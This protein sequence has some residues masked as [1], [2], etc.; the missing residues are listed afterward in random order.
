MLT[1]KINILWAIDPKKLIRN[2][3]ANELWDYTYKYFFL[4]AVRAVYCT[5]VSEFHQTAA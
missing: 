5:V 4:E 3:N 2:F 1:A